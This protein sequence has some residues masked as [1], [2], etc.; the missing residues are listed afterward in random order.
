MRSPSPPPL[1]WVPKTRNFSK[2]S[3]KVTFYQK[4][5]KSA[6]S[7]KNVKKCQKVPKSAFFDVVWGVLARFFC[8]GAKIC[9]ARSLIKK[10]GGGGYPPPPGGGQKW[11]VWGSENSGP[12]R[13]HRTPFERI[14]ALEDHCTSNHVR[15][16]RHGLPPHRCGGPVLVCAAGRKDPSR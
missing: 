12:V 14:A 9:I 15:L 3:K 5:P 4:V 13:C 7:A 10:V 16:L 1:F 6:K 11:V 2:K 8:E